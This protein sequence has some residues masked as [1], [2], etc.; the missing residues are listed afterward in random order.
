MPATP[1]PAAV[2]SFSNVAPAQSLKKESTPSPDRS[3]AQA[4]PLN[5]PA[6]SPVNGRVGS[7]AAL[8]GVSPTEGEALRSL[9]QQKKLSAP[10][11][12]R[13]AQPSASPSM[14]PPAPKAQIAMQE[15]AAPQSKAKTSSG[16]AVAESAPAAA[17]GN[18]TANA[19]VDAPAL[20]KQS[21]ASR[22]LAGAMVVPQA[23]SRIDALSRKR[24]SSADLKTNEPATVQATAP[25]GSSVWRM[26]KNGRI[27]RSADAGETWVPQVSPSQDEWLAAAAVS[28]TVCWV[29]GRNGSIARTADGE[30]WERIAPPAL[31]AAN[32]ARLPDWTGITARDAQ[33]ATITA[34]DGRKFST[35]DGGK[36]WQRQ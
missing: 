29:G 4:S 22:P 6:Q 35:T 28:D 32:G 10:T 7:G 24:Q 13:E 16:N 34:N 3:A 25:F 2:D 18:A 12:G 33:S 23:S 30:S 8:G 26:G 15:P 11:E 36:T 31:V 20:D 1:A 27:E 17:N 5:S 19:V 14:P 9:Q 21:S